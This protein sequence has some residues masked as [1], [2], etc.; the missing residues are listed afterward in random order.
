MEQLKLIHTLKM[1]MIASLVTQELI[2]ELLLIQNQMIL[3]R[4]RKIVDLKVIL[5]TKM[6]KLLFLILEELAISPVHAI[7]MSENTSDFQIADNNDD[8]PIM[9]KDK[10]R[11]SSFKKLSHHNHP[12]M[13]KKRYSTIN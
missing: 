13:S 1:R 11:T 12:T 3:S 7:A 9:I 4:L 5:L 10:T 8:F 2:L 6:S